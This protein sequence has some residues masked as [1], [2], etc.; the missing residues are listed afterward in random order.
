MYLKKIIKIILIILLANLTSYSQ[1]SICEYE[2]KS[3]NLFYFELDVKFERT[4]YDSNKGIEI[5]VKCDSLMKEDS[6][7]S[8]HF[9]SM[10]YGYKTTWSETYTYKEDIL[11]Y[12]TSSLNNHK[13][14]EIYDHLSNEKFK[15]KEVAFRIIGRNL[16]LSTPLCNYDNLIGIEQKVGNDI[17][18][19]YFKK[20]FGLIATF[21]NEKN[22][23]YLKKLKR[24]SK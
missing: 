16:S 1:I 10:S 6:L 12:S 21:D 8:Y 2:V 14:Y 20:N 5:I 22:I 15:E 24:I 17:S 11:Y 4:Y 18:L 7:F 9:T 13:V 23:C 19:S 3:N